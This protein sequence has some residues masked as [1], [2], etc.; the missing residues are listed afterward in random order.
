MDHKGIIRSIKYRDTQNQNL[1]NTDQSSPEFAEHKQN[2]AAYNELL[3]QATWEAKTTYYEN[4]LHKNC[5]NMRKMWNTISE[6]IHK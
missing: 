3:K 1:K 6:S 5:T 4:E 2:S